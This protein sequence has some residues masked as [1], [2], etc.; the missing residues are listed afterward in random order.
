MEKL[1]MTNI[2]EHCS[3]DRLLA[4]GSSS[5]SLLHTCRFLIE[6]MDKE[7]AILLLDVKILS[8]AIRH[9]ADE[10]KA[11]ALLMRVGGLLPRRSDLP[12]I[13]NL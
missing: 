2:G 1:A 13:G 10:G 7:A 12:G 11:F 3:K 4:A 5:S 6:S 9:R 8:Y